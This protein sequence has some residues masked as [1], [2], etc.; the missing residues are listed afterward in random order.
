MFSSALREI[1]ATDAG[2]MNFGLEI[3]WSLTNNILPE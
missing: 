3:E 2:I 1:N